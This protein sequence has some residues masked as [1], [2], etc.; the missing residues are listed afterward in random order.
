MAACPAC[1]L[2]EYGFITA[3][4]SFKI[5]FDKHLTLPLLERLYSYQNMFLDQSGG[6]FMLTIGEFSRISKVSPKTLR[7]Y[8]QI[9]LLKPGFVSRESG[10]RYYEASQLRDMLLISRLKQYRFS[11]PEIAAVAAR[12]D[13]GYLSALIQAKKAQLSSQISDQQRILLQMERDIEKIERCENIMQSNYLIKTVAFQPK[14]IFSLRQKMSLQDFGEV[15]GELFAGLEKARVKPAGPCLS[16]YYD[17]EFS[18]ECTDIEVGVMVAEGS[19]ENIR[20]LDPGF[21]CFATHIGPYDDF[22]PCYAALAEWIEREGYTVSG[23]PIELYVKGC[24]DN[25]QPAE[26]VTEIYFPIKK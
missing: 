9:G 7:Y 15:F 1:F 8:D 10:Y 18:R 24:E 6:D 20:K 14:N 2:S 12:Q 13:N 17:E 11:L 21:C 4:D 5:N 25:V 19:G 16:I 3:P 26:Y 23:P 22:T